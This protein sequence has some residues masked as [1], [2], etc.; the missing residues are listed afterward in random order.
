MHSRFDAFRSGKTFKVRSGL[1]RILFSRR[2]GV[3]V[4]M[5]VNLSDL[6]RAART[7]PSRIV[8]T[9]G[10]SSEQVGNEK[11]KQ[12]KA[13]LWVCKVENSDKMNQLL[14]NSV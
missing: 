12:E 5:P 7:D 9:S 6:L 3:D 11:L 1:L 10:K 8:M 14:E 13:T 2:C 4:Y